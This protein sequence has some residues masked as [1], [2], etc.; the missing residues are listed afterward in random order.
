[1]V[2]ELCRMTR[3][4]NDFSKDKYCRFCYFYNIFHALP[5]LTRLQRYL[6]EFRNKTLIFLNSGPKKIVKPVNEENESDFDDQ[7]NRDILK[8]NINDDEEEDND[9]AD[10][11]IDKNNNTSYMNKKACEENDENISV[12][13]SIENDECDGVLNIENDY[14]DLY[15]N[16]FENSV[17]TFLYNIDC[18][19]FKIDHNFL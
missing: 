3:K 16:Y 1:L 15:N 2:V 4:I 10:F 5:R 18:R 7:E 8:R 9:D 11:D 12:D 6:V 14:Y 17:S 19:L 13:Q